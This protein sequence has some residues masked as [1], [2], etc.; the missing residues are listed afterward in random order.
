MITGI[1]RS[2]RWPSGSKFYQRRH[3]PIGM[4]CRHWALLSGMFALCLLGS[5]P[6]LGGWEGKF[7]RTATVWK[8]TPNIASLDAGM[9]ATAVAPFASS[10]GFAFLADMAGGQNVT[11]QWVVLLNSFVLKEILEGS[12]NTDDG[13]ELAEKFWR[14]GVSWMVRD[15]HGMGLE[16]AI[17]QFQKMLR[18]PN[19]D[20]F[21]LKPKNEGEPE[22][23]GSI[24]PPSFLGKKPKRE[25]VLESMKHLTI[26][27]T[28]AAD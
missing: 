26:E 11:N 28:D 8:H 13:R 12:V 25:G 27:Q 20:E 3:L 24:A 23:R 2:S 4:G 21:M 22:I 14:S 16:K 9:V 15:F 5:T 1:A 18:S 17:V 10:N 19:P 6:V 7:D